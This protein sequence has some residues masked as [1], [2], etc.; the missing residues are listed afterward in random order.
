MLKLC[1][2]LKLLV[3]NT[4]TGHLPVL[5]LPHLDSVISRVVTGTGGNLTIT[6]SEARLNKNQIFVPFHSLEDV[7]P[8][9]LQTRQ[10]NPP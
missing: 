10:T 3:T 4:V 1:S 7:N 2:D 5:D 8:L 6:I 9:A